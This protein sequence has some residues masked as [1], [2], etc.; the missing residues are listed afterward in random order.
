MWG[1]KVRHKAGLLA[2]VGLLLLAACSN[3]SAQPPTESVSLSGV[4][5]Q[6]GGQL[7]LGG[8]SLD[9][10]GARV[11]VDGEEATSQALQ[12]GVV[13]SGSGERSADRMRLREVEVQYRVRGVVDAVDVAQGSLE[14]LG[15][16]VQVNAMTYLYEENPD[17]TY[18]RLTL[19][20]LQ[21]GDYVKVA[22]IPQDDDT[23]V[24]TR[25]E[26][27]PI[28]PTDPAYSRVSLRVRVR[29]LNTSAF[30]FS[31]GLKTYTVNYAS[32]L[33]QGT[34]REGAMVEVKGAQSGQTIQ[35]SKVRVYGMT[36]PGTKL[37]LSGPLANLDETAK[38]FRLMEYT[39][40]Y[41]GARVKGTLREGAWVKVE[42]SL[43][44]GV[45]MA[46][47]VEVKYSHSG[48]GPYTGEIEGPLSAVD[49]AALTLQVGNQTF[50]ADANTLI[51][52]N[53]AQGQFS[54]LRVGDWVEVKFDTGR[55]NS[56]GQAYA[57]KIEVKRYAATPSR[58]V[59]LEG[60]LTHFDAAAR[61]FQVN[62]VQ[63]SVTPSTRYEVYD[64]LV[65]AEAFFGADRTGARVEVKGFLNSSGLEASKV[66]V[67]KK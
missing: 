21:P 31:Y 62:G 23:I 46:Y 22:G 17:D 54:D 25:I 3:P 8:L 64:K 9:A 10:S 57:V 67:K 47:E 35:A 40:N 1:E 30:T 29:D 7:T 41:A 52:W 27:K 45:L 66:E 4:V 5:G 60:T 48:S 33:V 42:G 61:T 44:N 28:A 50:W 56:A 20:D 26:R 37:E 16:K 38:T 6:A 59:E 18:T 36:S 51:K 34:L 15:L 49:T 65:T 19:A 63:V 13:L 58:P 11:L 55:A 53:D 32:A 14:V 39:V 24:A 12:P 2:F 43:S